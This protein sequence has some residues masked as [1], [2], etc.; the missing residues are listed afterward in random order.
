MAYHRLRDMLR[1]PT[2]DGTEA[3]KLDIG[4]LEITYERVKPSAGSAARSS[5]KG[6]IF[7]ILSGTMEMT[8]DGEKKAVKAGDTW[9]VEAGK[10]VSFQATDIECI[11]LIITG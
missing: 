2:A 8:V 1:T 5:D 9:L 3:A 7:Y 10:P 6:Q 4:H 11:R